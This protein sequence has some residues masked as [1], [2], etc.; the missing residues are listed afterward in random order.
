MPRVHNLSQKHHA[1]L[2]TSEDDLGLALDDVVVAFASN[3]YFVPY[4]S[5]AIQSLLENVGPTRSYDVIVLTRDLSPA[6]MLTLETQVDEADNVHIGFLDVEAAMGGARLP[7][8]GHFRPETYFRFAAPSLL[9]HVDKAI[10]LDSDIVVLDDVAKLYDIDVTGKL[11][12]A[13]RDADTVGQVCGYDEGVRAYLTDDLG[14]TDPL[15]YFQAGVLLMNLE[16]FRRQTT[17][18][19]LIAMA[20]R[21]T[22]RWLDQDVLNRLVDGD[23]VR[24]PM[25]W[26]YLYDWKGLRRDH[27]IACAPEDF[28][29]EYADARLDLG[30]V[31]YAGPNDRPWLYP[32]C[33]LGGYFWDYA[34]R[35]PYIGTLR[36]RLEES[37][38]DPRQMR[39]RIKSSIELDIA[40]VGF[41]FFFPPK[42][43][44]RRN[45]IGAYMRMGGSI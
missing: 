31:H 29:Q 5:V 15:Q 2:A 9:P 4:L 40:M 16:E 33:D 26:N 18:S 34:R 19:Q 37:R 45:F 8:Y 24:I 43:R 13:T 41:D 44:R 20:T 6:S 7:H 39:E 17:L 12:G 1:L 27:I 42:T 38:T 36:S 11:L 23:Y 14:L 10:Y 21:R 32:G 35:C 30:I 3:D 25:R 22:W 28:R